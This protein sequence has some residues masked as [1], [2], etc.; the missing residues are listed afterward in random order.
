MNVSACNPYNA[1]FDG[2]KMS[3]CNPIYA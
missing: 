3:V 2:M 1:D